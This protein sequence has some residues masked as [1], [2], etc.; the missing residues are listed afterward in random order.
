MVKLPLKVA[1]DWSATVWIDGVGDAERRLE[2][3]PT[4]AG[5]DVLSFRSYTFRA[6][7]VIAGESASD[8]M[9]MVLLSGWV[10]IEVVGPGWSETWDC[11]GRSNVF[12]GP[13]FAIY[14]PPGYTYRTTVHSD[15]DCAYGRAPASG[16]R[17]PR[18]F[19]PK[20]LSSGVN[21]DGN[22]FTPILTL[23]DAEHLLCTETIVL[24]GSW[25]T[26]S[27]ALPGASTSPGE[28]VAYYRLNPES[29]WAIQRF[30]GD[31]ANDA[32]L[33][34]RNGDAIASRGMQQQL[35]AAPET[36]AYVLNFLAAEPK[37]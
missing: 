31:D 5:W 24:P 6:G 3:T 32:V 16:V 29:G 21:R 12:D 18:F 25:D 35:I 37:D 17:P 23:D 1:S 33:L 22:R 19:S 14:L 8:E 7:Q 13:P 2:I 10:T 9:A 11:P 4:I 27:L 30:D 36:T 26:Q 34:V 28:Q 15:A 20:S